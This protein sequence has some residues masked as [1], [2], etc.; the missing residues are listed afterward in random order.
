MKDDNVAVNVAVTVLHENGRTF[1]KE[2]HGCEKATVT[3]VPATTGEIL[4]WAR[5]IYRGRLTSFQEV[6]KNR[7]GERVRTITV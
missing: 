5:D 3:E 6:I 1:L 2:C 4:A 7:G